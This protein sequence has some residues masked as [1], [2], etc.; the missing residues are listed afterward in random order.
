MADAMILLIRI[1]VADP[2]PGVRLALQRGATPTADRLPPAIET[3]ERIAFDFDIRAEGALADGRPRLLGAFVQGP[4]T[5]RFVYLCV[6]QAAG[7]LNSEW[8]RRIK[9]PLGGLAWD[10]MRAAGPGTR[11]TARI[12]GRGR[13]GSP[14]CASVPLLPPGWRV[15]PIP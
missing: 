14:A 9:V 1:E 5:A 4:P 8:N 2:V 13:D 3:P 12:A 6:G 10:Q 7:Q 15:E 11:L